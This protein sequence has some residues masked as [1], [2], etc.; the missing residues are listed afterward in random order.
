MAGN[1]AI[2][3]RDADRDEERRDN[4]ICDWRCFTVDYDRVVLVTESSHIMD[5]Y[6][7]QRRQPVIL[8]GVIF[9]T[10][11]SS[12]K[13]LS[14]LSAFCTLRRRLINRQ[15]VRLC[16]AKFEGLRSSSPPPPNF[17]RASACR[18]RYC[19]TNSV[20]PSVC[21]MPVLCRNDGTYRQTFSTFC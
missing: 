10:F 17:Y 13:H 11:W 5:K 2:V 7:R 4:Y 20:R 1:I 21:P 6:R 19:F 16:S 12:D 14:M 9:N 8:T 3:R 18:A 15:F